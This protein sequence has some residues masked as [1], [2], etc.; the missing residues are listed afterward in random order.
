MTKK[1]TNKNGAKNGAQR[2]SKEQQRLLAKLDALP[3]PVTE[4]A[5][6][7]RDGARE[8]VLSG[9]YRHSE[10]IIREIMEGR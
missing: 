5:K 2:L 9:E 10:K 4:M 8:I 3:E 1:R 6:A 7:M